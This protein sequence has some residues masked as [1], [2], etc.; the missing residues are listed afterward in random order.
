MST[1]KPTDWHV[2][3]AGPKDRR[4]RV[5]PTP[6]PKSK[7][8]A[9]IARAA[10]LQAQGKDSHEIAEKLGIKVSHLLYA[11][12]TY[13]ELWKTALDKLMQRT[14][15][16]VRAM[17]CSDRILEDAPAYM[18]MADQADKWTAAHGQDLFPKVDG[19]TTLSSFYYE[20]YRPMRLGEA[21]L[22][23]LADHDVILRRWRLITTDP[24]LKDIT[25]QILAGFR[26]VSLNL[27]GQK[28]YKKA[29]PNSVRSKMRF[30]Q[31]VLDRAGPVGP[32]RRDAVG[33]LDHVPWV[34]P[35]Q[36]RITQPRIVSPEHLE[37]TYK[38]LCLA[39]KPHLP[40]IK[41]GA[42]WRALVVFVYFTGVR[43]GTLFKLR[44]NQIDRDA[45][46]VNIPADSI[47]G[48]RPLSIP[49]VDVVLEHL[50][51]IRTD[52]ELIFPWPYNRNTF[53]EHFHR[54]QNEAGVPKKE[55]FGLHALRKTLATNLTEFGSVDVAR[56][57]LGHAAADVTERHYIRTDGIIAKALGRVPV[58]E[59]FKSGG[60]KLDDGETPA[61]R[62]DRPGFET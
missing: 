22:H 60:K 50:R 1:P 38:V 62:V 30:I 35:P 37:A 13:P 20:Y 58:P 2:S 15:D 57:M 59:V 16:V 27:R 12:E 61:V 54:L 42:W 4:H 34:K 21:S 6:G 33:I 40:G 32:Y 14:V 53:Y 8:V 11:K 47:K 24:P 52:R 9:L 48:N 23:T 46:V 56:F 17:V 28:P 43:R 55:Q 25:V 26:D 18:Q 49:L 36:P 19:A 51:A 10:V 3:P 29:S 44:T 31:Y 45:H 7:T 39:E 41:P 5:G